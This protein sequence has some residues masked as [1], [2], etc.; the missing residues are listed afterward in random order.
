MHSATIPVGMNSRFVSAVLA[1][2]AVVLVAGCAGTQ[3]SGGGAGPGS[4]TVTPTVSAAPVGSAV[5]PA[6]LIPTRPSTAVS[7]PGR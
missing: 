2:I 6:V 3:P 4:G 5:P 1:L 7:M